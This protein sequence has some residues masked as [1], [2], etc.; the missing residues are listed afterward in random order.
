MSERSGRLSAQARA[1]RIRAFREELA[2]LEL[3]QGVALTGDQRARITA[4]HDALIAELAGRYDIDTTATQKQL[5]LG[6]RIASFLGALAFCI[7]VVLFVERFWGGLTTGM[8]VALLILATLVPLVLAE[9]AARRERTL[10][11]A[12]LAALVAFA[13]FVTNLSL[14]GQIYN[15]P[16]TQHAFAL[17]GGFA[18]ALAYGYGLRLLLF[19]GLVCAAIWVGA[20]LVTLGGWPWDQLWM[21]TEFLLPA[22]AGALLLST[23]PHT[24]IRDGLESVARLFGLILLFV[25]VIWYA[26]LGER[27]VLPLSREHVEVAYQVTGFALAALAIWAG[28]R[29]NWSDITNTGVIAFTILLFIKAVDW[30]WDWMPRYLFFLVLG[31]MTLGVMVLLKR[32][33][34]RLAG[35][36]A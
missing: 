34:G 24:G 11:F 30:W 7:A 35:G 25:V 3:E 19:A 9:V 15:I 5:A 36:A 8:Q 29:R 28:I 22:A 32:I 21:R 12:G 23:R 1:D 20:T 13:A 31:G 27:S 17:W 14:L 26:S 2:A 33:R 4:H 18:L 6:L 16:P 10:Y